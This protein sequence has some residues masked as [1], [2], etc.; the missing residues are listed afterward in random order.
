MAELEISQKAFNAFKDRVAIVS[1]RYDKF[2]T[3]IEQE[4]ELA[5]SVATAYEELSAA[6]TKLYAFTKDP[7]S[8]LAQLVEMDVHVPDAMRELREKLEDPKQ[9]LTYAAFAKVYFGLRSLDR[10]PMVD[11]GRKRHQKTDQIKAAIEKEYRVFHERQEYD[12]ITF[13]DRGARKGFAEK[14]L[15]KFS[16]QTNGTNKG[17]ALEVETIKKWMREFDKSLPKNNASAS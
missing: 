11:G 13:G 7:L 2:L 5:G 17:P 6:Y 12:G 10:K 15:D 4:L 3:K 9:S 16:G 8:E 14:M 1:A